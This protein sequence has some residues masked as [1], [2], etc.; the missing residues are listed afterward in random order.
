MATTPFSALR[1]AGRA[2]ATRVPDAVSLPDAI[3]LR[4]APL[5]SLV[6]ARH[7]ASAKASPQQ[8]KGGKQASEQPAT[9]SED[10]ELKLSDLMPA[11]KRRADPRD[12]SDPLE[13]RT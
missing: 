7:L 2:L 5:P 1:G 6:G 4:R 3:S 12:G 11:K 9:V 10:F 8:D 13:V